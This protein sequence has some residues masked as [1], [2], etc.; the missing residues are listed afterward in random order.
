METQKI[1]LHSDSESEIDRGENGT[2][3]E[4]AA[5]SGNYIKLGPTRRNEE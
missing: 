3:L 5:G 1:D 2:S 4:S